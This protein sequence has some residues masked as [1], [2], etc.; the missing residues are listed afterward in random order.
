[1]G[2]MELPIMLNAIIYLIY[3][4]WSRVNME[5]SLEDIP[6]SNL[7]RNLNGMQIQMLL[8]SHFQTRKKWNILI[9]KHL[10]LFVQVLMIGLFFLDIQ[11]NFGYTMTVIKTTKVI[12]ILV[13][14]L[15]PLKEL[16]TT[17]INLKIIWQVHII[18]KSKK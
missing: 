9:P 1:M 8:Y 12:A 3:L 11:K 16:L 2:L 13:K 14:L 6:V 15:K 17:Q 7:I 5:G 4:M 18:L 10:M